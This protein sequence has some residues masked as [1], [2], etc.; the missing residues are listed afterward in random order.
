MPAGSVATARSAWAPADS[1]AAK[2][3]ALPATLAVPSA[4]VPSNTV[5]VVPGAPVSV[6]DRLRAPLLVTLSAALVPVSCASA[7]PVIATVG[8]GV[9]APTSRMTGWSPRVIC[10][11][12]TSVSVSIGAAPVR[13]SKIATVWRK[14]PRSTVTV[15]RGAATSVPV[16]WFQ[17][18]GSAHSTTS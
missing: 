5:T 13:G 16:A 18:V 7:C 14:P 15:W 10:A 3:Q 8:A 6:P 1:V 2:L 11:V 12:R 4:R 17:S 9:G